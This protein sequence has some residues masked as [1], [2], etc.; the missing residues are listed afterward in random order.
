MPSGSGPGVPSVTRSLLDARV[1]DPARMLYVEPARRAVGNSRPVPPAAIPGASTSPAATAYDE[2]FL[3]DGSSMRGRVDVV[4]AG[5]VIFQDRRTGLRHEIRKDEID[6]I[7][8]EFGAPVRFRVAENV[9]AATNRAVMAARAR[10]ENGPRGRGVSGVYDV[11]YGSADAVGSK[12][13]T[14]LWTKPPNT[15]DVATVRHAAGADTLRVL[16]AGGDNFLSNMD[17]D[18]YFASTF[19]IVPDQARTSTAL[20]TRLTGQFKT[21]GALALQ[22]IIVFYRRMRAGDDI[23]CTVS[24]NAVGRRRSL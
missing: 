12:E 13:C 11:R 1:V 2:V 10:A 23:T 16:F 8:T 20:T 17:A 7:V 5:T 3:N 19:R 9:P 22:V 4:R 6:R 21:D 14:D 18:G 24:V 15:I